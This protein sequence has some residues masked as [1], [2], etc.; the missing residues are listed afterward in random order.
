VALISTLSGAWGGLG[1]ALIAYSTLHAS[2]DLS[3]WSY[4]GFVVIGALIAPTASPLYG[5]LIGAAASPALNLAAYYGSAYYP[6]AY[7]LAIGGGLL[8]TY[9]AVVAARR[10]VAGR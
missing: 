10:Y 1:G 6:G 7:D 4:S 2:P 3:F 5:F 9:A 8:A